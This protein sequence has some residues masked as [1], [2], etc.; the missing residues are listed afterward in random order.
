MSIR[1]PLVACMAG[2]ALACAT[3]DAPPSRAERGTILGALAGAAIG[4]AISGHEH[5]ADG[6]LLGATAG[7]VAGGAVGAYLDEQA[8]RIDAI[9]GT[10]VQR[11]VDSLLV[12]L[13]GRVL[14]ASGSARLQAGGF[15]QLR[16][17]ARTLNAYP[18]TQVRVRGHTD[19]AGDPMSNQRLSEARADRV[20][21]FLI[22]EGVTPAR[23][24]AIG[25]GETLPIATNASESG[26]AR[27]R[28]VEVEIRPD[29]RLA[30]GATH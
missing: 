5:R 17:L 26:R 15:E 22:A 1:Q 23:I 9:P 24:T 3:L 20:R 4:A 8:S 10:E 28:R 13:E 7:L 30:G 16:A 14:F 27:N 2:A 12:S 18:H 25:F 21:S 29:P 11:R 19:G 6:V